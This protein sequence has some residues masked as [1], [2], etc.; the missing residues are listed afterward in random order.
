MKYNIYHWSQMQAEEY[1]PE[2]KRTMPER[3]FTEFRVLSIDRRVITR[4]ALEIND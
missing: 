3:W 4:S 1:Q 2:G